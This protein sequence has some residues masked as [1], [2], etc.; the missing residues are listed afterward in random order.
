MSRDVIYG[1]LGAGY[2]GLA[3][4]K[5]RVTLTKTNRNNLSNE[6]RALLKICKMSSRFV[7]RWSIGSSSHVVHSIDSPTRYKSRRQ[8]VLRAVEP[9]VSRTNRPK[10]K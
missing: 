4:N 5:K 9:V 6:R 1:P 8:I 3:D 7:S 10:A 2:D